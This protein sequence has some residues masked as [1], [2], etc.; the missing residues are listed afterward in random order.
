MFA[1]N[2]KPQFLKFLLTQTN[3]KSPQS[4]MVRSGFREGSQD[5]PTP[6]NPIK[7]FR[8]DPERN[9]EAVIY[10]KVVLKIC[11]CKTTPTF[12]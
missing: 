4:I 10:F 9:I 6:L 2:W 11:W 8:G 7:K 5:F 12:N 3:L 1:K